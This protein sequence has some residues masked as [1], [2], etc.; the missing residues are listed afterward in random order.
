MNDSISPNLGPDLSIIQDFAHSKEQKRPFVVNC[1]R[2][3]SY[4]KGA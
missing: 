2:R 3:A 1:F 4:L